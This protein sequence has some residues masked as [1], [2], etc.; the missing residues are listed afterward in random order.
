MSRRIGTG[1]E[2]PVSTMSRAE[3][4]RGHIF[5]T[6]DDEKSTFLKT[7][8][9]VRTVEADTDKKGKCISELQD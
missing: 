7:E 2:G 4:A 6:G 9:R 3:P 5:I 1:P 8:K